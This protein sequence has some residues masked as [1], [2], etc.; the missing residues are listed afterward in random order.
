MN[1]YDREHT[2]RNTS[3]PWMTDTARNFQN[4]QLKRSKKSLRPTNMTRLLYTW[5]EFSEGT[6]MKALDCYGEEGE[7]NPSDPSK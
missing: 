1:E 5:N 7:T 3:T 4:A 2:Y 6:K